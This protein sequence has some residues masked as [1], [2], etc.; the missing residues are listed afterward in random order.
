MFDTAGMDPVVGNRETPARVPVRPQGRI[1]VIARLVLHDDAG[2]TEVWVP[3]AAIRWTS[4]HVLVT[5]HPD[6]AAPARTSTCWL[7]AVDVARAVRPRS[8]WPGFARRRRE[9]DPAVADP[10]TVR[11]DDPTSAHGPGGR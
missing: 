9:S 8:P 1:E 7:R 10:A 2:S 3:A 11:P 4:T 5:W 6:V